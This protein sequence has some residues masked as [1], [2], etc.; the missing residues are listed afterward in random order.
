MRK[1]LNKMSDTKLFNISAD[2]GRHTNNRHEAIE[3]I[4]EQAKTYRWSIEDI[5]SRFGI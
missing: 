1:Y 3:F 4:F 2:L 5:I